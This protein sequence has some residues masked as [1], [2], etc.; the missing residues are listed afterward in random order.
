MPTEIIVKAV[1]LYT[2]DKVILRRIVNKKLPKKG[3]W[4]SYAPK[5]KNKRKSKATERK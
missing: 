5:F 1:N 4:V 2:G 3:R